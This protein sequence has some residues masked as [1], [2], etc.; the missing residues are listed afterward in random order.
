VTTF[1]AEIKYRA[2]Q[3]NFLLSKTGKW[4]SETKQLTIQCSSGLSLPELE[5]ENKLAPTKRTNSL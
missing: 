5:T 2:A 3:E 1:G 4:D